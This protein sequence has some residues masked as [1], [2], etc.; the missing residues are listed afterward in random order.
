MIIDPTSPPT[1]YER[2]ELHFG[3]ALAFIVDYVRTNP[4]GSGHLLEESDDVLMEWYEKYNF[5]RHSLE[6]AVKAFQ[7]AVINEKYSIKGR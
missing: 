6:I 5:N 2:P 3:N 7:G 4:Y 1:E